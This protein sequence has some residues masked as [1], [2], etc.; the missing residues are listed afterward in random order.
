MSEEDLPTRFEKYDGDHIVLKRIALTAEQVTGLPSF[1]ADD[2][3]GDP[4]Y[5]WFVANHGLR[6]WELD[7]MDP[8]VLRD[9][10]ERAIKELIEPIA[11]ARCDVVNQAERESLQTVLDNWGIPLEREADWI[12]AMHDYQRGDP[13]DRDP[14]DLL[15]SLPPPA[16]PV[17]DFNI[18]GA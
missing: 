15:P 10:V 13:L 18:M 7:A 1:P 14:D 2:K 6:C 5:K 12:E 8:N 11:W 3:R 4:R 17:G 9:C 16:A